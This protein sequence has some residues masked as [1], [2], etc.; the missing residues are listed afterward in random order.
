LIALRIKSN[1]LHVNKTPINN[2]QRFIR[3]HLFI[4]KLFT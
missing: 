4:W 2:Q 1:F 3:I